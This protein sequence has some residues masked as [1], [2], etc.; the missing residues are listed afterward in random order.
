MSAHR[1]SRA[2]IILHKNYVKSSI[3]DLVSFAYGKAPGEQTELREPPGGPNRATKPPLK[4]TATTVRTISP[5]GQ[6][7]QTNPLRQQVQA[8]FAAAGQTASPGRITGQT[9]PLGENPGEARI[10]HAE[11]HLPEGKLGK[12]TPGITSPGENSSLSRIT[13]PR[14]TTGQTNPLED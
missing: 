6:T 14:R 7:G 11:R 13:S 9:N 2:A 10:F 12:Q 5:G 8:T 1:S 4:W 3:I